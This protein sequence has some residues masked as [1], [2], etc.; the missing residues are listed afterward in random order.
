MLAR[1]PWVKPVAAKP[2]AKR[3]SK[4]RRRLVIDKIMVILN[5]GE[6]TRFA[7]EGVCRHAIRSHLCLKGWTWKDADDT[8]TDVVHTALILIDARRPAWREGQPEYTQEGFAPIARTRCTRCR[9][10]LN[11]DQTKFCSTLCANAHH[12]HL[13]SVRQAQ[14][15][16]AYDLVIKGASRS[17]WKF[18]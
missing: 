1:T 10:P 5:L 6:P 3:L 17:W 13:A 7:L 11:G 9:G 15:A 4:D 14:E 8:A 2:K 16:M 18:K 12:M